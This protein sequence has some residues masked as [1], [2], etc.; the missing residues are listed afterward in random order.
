MIYFLFLP[1][2]YLIRGAVRY[3]REPNEHYVN[4]TLCMFRSS[5]AFI[6]F[7]YPELIHGND[8]APWFQLHQSMISRLRAKNTAA[9]TG[10][11]T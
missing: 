11:V 4:K 7:P 8:Q 10:D 3:S 6:A 1:P 9:G 5:S 2:H